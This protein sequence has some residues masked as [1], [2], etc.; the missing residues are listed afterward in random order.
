MGIY[1]WI[2]LRKGDREQAF[3]LLSGAVEPAPEDRD[4]RFHYAS[5]MAAASDDQGAIKE[6]E[7]ILGT[8]AVF[9]SRDQAQVLLEQLQE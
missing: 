3:D 9:S 5:T 1:G 7:V 4:I 6:P 2:L 8:D